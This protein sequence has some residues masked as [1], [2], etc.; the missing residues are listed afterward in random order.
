MKKVFLLLTIG[1]SLLI[2]CNSPQASGETEGDVSETSQIQSIVL[3]DIVYV[4]IDVLTENYLMTQDLEATLEEKADR[5][6]AD[7]QNRQRRFQQQVTDLQNRAQRGL[8]TQRRLN[9][10][11]EQ[12]AQEEQTLM[13]FFENSRNEL[14]EEQMVMQRQILQAIMDYL[15]E[16]NKERGYKYILGNAFGSNILFADPSLNITEEV[17]EGLN[18]KYRAEN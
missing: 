15:E 1:V 11:G 13:Q 16:Y 2:S 12:L 6:Q 18:A 7:F 8:E 9:E 17:L 10:M 5:F 14:A 4:D 3:G